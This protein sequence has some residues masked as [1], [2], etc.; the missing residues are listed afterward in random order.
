M[1]PILE[2]VDNVG[3]FVVALGGALSV[4]FLA[5][6]GIMWMA[7]QGDPQK[8]AQA[9]TGFIGVL[10]GL[11]VV[12]CA[13]LI[14]ATISRVIIE[15]SGGVALREGVTQNDCDS[16]LRR[17][18]VIQRGVSSAD[19]MNLLV[20]RI[21]SQYDA[22]SAQYWD[23]KILTS[24]ASESHWD[25]DHGGCFEEKLFANPPRP[26]SY[27]LGVLVV[28]YSMIASGGNMVVRSSRDGDNNVVVYF[29]VSHR[30]WDS[31]KCWFY[32]SSFDTWRGKN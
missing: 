5:Y 18:L 9:R 6:A 17:Q 31:A 3:L 11:V 24:D 32:W 21:Q 27:R 1:Q 28:P 20:A 29:D 14:P 7:A 26:R 2:L 23:V 19:R 30:P 10:V 12:G 25:S 15:P 8:A 13:L 4:V 22:C 16:I